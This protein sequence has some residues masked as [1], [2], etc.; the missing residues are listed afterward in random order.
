M[1][2][3][4]NLFEAAVLKAQDNRARDWRAMLAIWRDMRTAGATWDEAVGMMAAL[5]ASARKDQE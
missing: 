5:F 2:D 4:S 3:A 1:G